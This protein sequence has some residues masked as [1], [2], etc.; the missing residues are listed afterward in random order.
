MTSSD[1][2]EASPRP[3]SSPSAFAL[4]QSQQQ[5]QSQ[6]QQQHNTQH[7]QQQ[8]PHQS[9][10]K[11]RTSSTM[12]PPHS[13]SWISSDTTEKTTPM[14]SSSTMGGV[15]VAA[16][17][18]D[19]HMERQSF[20]RPAKAFRPLSPSELEHELEI[21]NERRRHQQLQQQQLQQQSHPFQQPPQSGQSPQQQQPTQEVSQSREQR[22]P[23][24]NQEQEA[25]YVA[26]KK[27]N[28]YG[29]WS[30]VRERME[31]SNRSVN[32][33]EN[34]YMRLYGELSES[35]DDEDEDEYYQFSGFGEMEG[36]VQSGHGHQRWA[37]APYPAG[38]QHHQQ[39][40][41]PYSE[42]NN[43]QHGRRTPSAASATS[44][45]SLSRRSS[46]EVFSTTT[47][48][49]NYYG[50][51]HHSHN[52]FYGRT[53]RPSSSSEQLR[54][55]ATTTIGP[56]RKSSHPH[57]AVVTGAIYR[58]EEDGF[59]DPMFMG[60][61]PPPSSAS[62]S[63]H[64]QIGA[65]GVIK[66]GMATHRGPTVGGRPR[67]QS[68]TA[69]VSNSSATNA[70]SNATTSAETKPTR[71]V[72]VW[73]PKQSDQLKSLIE[74]H[75]PGGFRIN[76]V[77]VASQMGNTFT[78][79]QCKNK[80]EIMRRRAGTD[81]EVRLLKLG[82]EEFGSDW[83]QIQEK[84]LPERSQGGISIMWNLLQTREAEE[85]LLQQ[86]QQQ[87][88]QQHSQGG[89]GMSLSSGQLQHQQSHSR[90]PS[91]AGSMEDPR[92]TGP[93]SGPASRSRSSS[94]VARSPVNSRK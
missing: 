9:Q 11:K 87:Q 6:F 58:P 47:N 68:D 22:H 78:R 4:T 64:R 36:L 69:L 93:Q 67:S 74:D 16:P 75:F 48:N 20:E 61:R 84:Y 83:C 14:S 49:H 81:E 1:M 37:S 52:P 79:K 18:D 62:S 27:H 45:S 35:E 2:N 8:Y 89:G 44:S 56:Y 19:D 39:P 21:E 88:Q 30:E 25:L 63:S 76:W 33:I 57:S 73:T 12:S 38:H 66:A 50:T 34:E 85:A 92:P 91:S 43:H 80:W 40:F 28:L 32:E 41:T 31:L 55:S 46:Q 26:V 54:H 51:H 42:H 13:A 82:Y 10:H 5:Q 77:W 53:T 24:S 60:I 65:S 59:D 90:R 23:W 17:D 70:A 86:E 71:T 72:R 15:M 3:N 7:H 29:R 94:T